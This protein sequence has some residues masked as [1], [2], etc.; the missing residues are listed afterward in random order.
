MGNQQK[1]QVSFPYAKRP[2]S[3]VKF[4]VKILSADFAENLPKTL[5]SG[6]LT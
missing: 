1:E 2:S 3:T 4:S 5:L 6:N